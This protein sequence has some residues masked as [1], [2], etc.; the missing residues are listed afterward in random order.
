MRNARYVNL[1]VQH[2]QP[3]NQHASRCIRL[4]ISVTVDEVHSRWKNLRDTFRKKMNDEKGT[5]KSGAAASSK[6]KVWPYMDQM[7]FLRDTLG[8]RK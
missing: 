2:H 6:S 8:L 4:D 5:K 3:F 7:Q 1:N